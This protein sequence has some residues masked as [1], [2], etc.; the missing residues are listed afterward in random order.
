MATPEAIALAAELLRQKEGLRS[1]PYWDVNALRAGYG[2]DTVTRP[3][4]SVQRVT[5]DT[6]VTRDW[7]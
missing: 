6:V 3:D 5:K 1:K 4:G 2:S 7:C